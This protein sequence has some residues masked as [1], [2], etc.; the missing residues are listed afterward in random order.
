MRGGAKLEMFG[1]VC[2]GRITARRRL[3]L[4]HV[5]TT[6]SLLDSNTISWA[7]GPLGY[8]WAT[9]LG[10][11]GLGLIRHFLALLLLR[12]RARLSGTSAVGK[13]NTTFRHVTIIQNPGIP[14][15]STN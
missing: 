10:W 7:T 4:Y 2:F 6:P 9:G 5:L 1:G 3:L 8:Y 13:L 14:G 12:L 15:L 11:A